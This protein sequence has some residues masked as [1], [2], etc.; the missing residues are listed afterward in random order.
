MVSGG[1]APAFKAIV[2]RGQNKRQSS[3]LGI[4]V[5]SMGFLHVESPR[6]VFGELRSPNI[7]LSGSAASLVH[8]DWTGKHGV[9]F[10]NLSPDRES[11]NPS[12]RMSFSLSMSD[13]LSVLRITIDAY[14]CTGRTKGGIKRRSEIDRKEGSHKTCWGPSHS[15]N[16]LALTILRIHL[17]K[18]SG[19]EDPGGRAGTPALPNP[20][21]RCLEGGIGDGIAGDINVH[22]FMIVYRSIVPAEPDPTWSGMSVKGKRPGVSLVR[23]RYDNRGCRR[24]RRFLASFVGCETS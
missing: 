12:N 14:G 19:E 20:L 9:A 1:A 17:H 24:G 2:A 15:G 22:R 8:F 21:A 10:Y 6:R 3:R 16:L 7:M 13:R 18:I 5:S 4:G 23:N 11:R